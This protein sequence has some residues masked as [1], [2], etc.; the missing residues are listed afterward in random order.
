[1]AS[2]E[3]L[4]SSVNRYR[5]LQDG[6]LDG[7]GKAPSHELLSWFESWFFDF[8]K[9]NFPGLDYPSLFPEFEGGLVLEWFLKGLQPSLDIF[10][11]KTGWFHFIDPDSPDGYYEID[12]NLTDSADTEWVEKLKRTLAV[13]DS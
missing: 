13:G 3:S 2:E 10:P 9:E 5:S 12:V 7:Q 11:E 1:M 8:Y 4:R 6:W